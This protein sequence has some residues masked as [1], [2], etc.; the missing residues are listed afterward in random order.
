MICDCLQGHPPSP[1][2]G[3]DA[4]AQEKANQLWMGLLQGEEP[5]EFMVQASSHASCSKEGSHAETFL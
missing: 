1:E 2:P 5:R 4:G 3:V